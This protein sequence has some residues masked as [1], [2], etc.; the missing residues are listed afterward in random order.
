[1]TRQCYI[2]FERDFKIQRDKKDRAGLV[3]TRETEFPDM[4]TSLNVVHRR[5]A[6]GRMA[7]HKQQQQQSFVS[8]TNVYK[9]N[10]S[11]TS[12]NELLRSDHKYGGKTGYNVELSFI[13]NYGCY[14][15]KLRS[16]TCWHLLESTHTSSGTLEGTAVY[17]ELSRVYHRQP[18]AKGIKLPEPE[19]CI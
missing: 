7:R 6:P 10:E 3:T 9:H 1:M 16:E 13:L 14:K 11:T 12:Y 8:F 17:Q 5:P 19:L 15:Y 2:P 4:E 18:I